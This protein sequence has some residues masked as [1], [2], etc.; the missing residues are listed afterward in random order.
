MVRPQHTIDDLRN[1]IV[2]WS[3]VVKD[4]NIKLD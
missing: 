1:E 2:K 4:A 3:R